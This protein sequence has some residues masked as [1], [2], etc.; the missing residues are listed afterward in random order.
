MTTEL[1]A[2]AKKNTKQK[3]ANNKNYNNK[4]KKKL[5]YS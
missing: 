3:K 5:N 4:Y 1:D 2:L